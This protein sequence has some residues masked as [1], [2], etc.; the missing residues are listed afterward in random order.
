MEDEYS[1]QCKYCKYRGFSR[2]P[3]KKYN[4]KKYNIPVLAIPFSS[5]ESRL[6]EEVSDLSEL[7][8]NAQKL[9]VLIGNRDKSTEGELQSKIDFQRIYES[10]DH[11]NQTIVSMLIEGYA[12]KE[13]AIKVGISEKATYA[14]VSKIIS[15]NR[16]E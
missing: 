1:L 4:W 10:L 13:I 6:P 16:V 12:Y 9:S 7:F 11:T 3:D 8:S 15:T 5:I 14:R 2:N